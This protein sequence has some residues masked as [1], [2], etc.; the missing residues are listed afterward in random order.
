MEPCPAAP[1]GAR[2]TRLPQARV[3]MGDLNTGPRAPVRRTGLRLL[4]MAPTF[5]ADNPDRQLD[6]ILTDD[7]GCRPRVRGAPAGDLGSPA[8]DRR[9]PSASRQVGTRRAEV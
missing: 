1:A 6:H 8:A 3:L 2:S 9:S 7:A 4:A 5:P